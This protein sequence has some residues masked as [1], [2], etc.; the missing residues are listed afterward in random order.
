MGADCEEDD[1]GDEDDKQWSISSRK[2]YI[3]VS[4]WKM[5]QALPFCTVEMTRL[6]VWCVHTSVWSEFNSL[7]LVY[8][9][10]CFR[11]SEWVRERDWARRGDWSDRPVVQ[12]KRGLYI[13]LRVVS[14]CEEGDTCGVCCVFQLLKDILNVHKANGNSRCVMPQSLCI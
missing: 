10:V 9:C 5:A 11:K 13:T 8:V 7:C 6:T 12:P 3:S 4:Q 14:E 1:G 2:L